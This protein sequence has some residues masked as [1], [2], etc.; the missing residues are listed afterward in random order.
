MKWL[1]HLKEKGE[2]EWSIQQLQVDITWIQ[3]TMMI[4]TKH[5]LPNVSAEENE[6]YET[7]QE[8][9]LLDGHALQIVQLNVPCKFKVM[10]K[11][12]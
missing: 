10:R 1:H 4:N 11:K 12:C 2:G 5:L 3:L 7:Y 9:H 6:Q 8:A